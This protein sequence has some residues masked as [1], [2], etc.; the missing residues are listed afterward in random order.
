MPIIAR[1]DLK[2]MNRNGHD[3]TA[4]FR[5]PFEKLAGLPPFVRGREIAVPDDK[6]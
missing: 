6:A 2:L 5:Q 1:G 3:R 4:L